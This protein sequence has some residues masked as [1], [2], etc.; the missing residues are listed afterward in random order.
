M[1]A[2]KP[3][4]PRFPRAL[5]YRARALEA[6]GR[7][8][9]V[10]ADTVVLLALDP[11]HRDAIDLSHRLRSHI[12][13]SSSSAERIGDGGLGSRRIWPEELPAARSGAGLA[14]R[15]RG[16]AGPRH[17][18]HHAFA[19]QRVQ[20][21]PVGDVSGLGQA[22]APFA[23]LLGRGIFLVGGRLWSLQRKLSS[24]YF[25]S[26]SLRRFSGRELRE[27][28]H[29]RLLPLLDAA[30]GSSVALDLQDVLRRFSFDNICGVAFDV[31]SST[32][33]ELEAPVDRNYVACRQP[34][35][36]FCNSEASGIGVLLAVQ[37]MPWLGA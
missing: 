14:L 33:L 1:P 9:L 30:A 31:V 11:N 2:R 34:R 24:Y 13:S 20:H 6:L 23:D 21:A 36:L 27:H 35:W 18:H 19:P 26:R 22:S 32:L 25:S 15:R 3:A 4:E 12:C 8:E 17:V 16:K 28:L 10:L 29:R 37:P 5:L 7:H